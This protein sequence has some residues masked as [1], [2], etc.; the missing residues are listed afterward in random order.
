MID[1]PTAF[2]PVK[3][4]NATSGWRTRCAPTSP[5]PGRKASAPGGTPASS[6]ISTSRKA[7]PGVC[8]AGLKT[9]QFPATRDALTMPA[10]MASGKFQGAMTAPTPRGW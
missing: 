9:T 3:T 4:T 8:S 6:R 2:E 1:S 5:I 10:G 7:I